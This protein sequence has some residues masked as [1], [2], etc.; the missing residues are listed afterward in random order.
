MKEHSLRDRLGNFSLMTFIFYSAHACYQPYIV[1]FLNARGVNAT[2]IGLI[3]T[4]NSLVAIFMQPLWGML[5]DHFRSVK[6]VAL[7]CIAALSLLIPVLGMLNNPL[8]ISVWIPL[9]NVFYC[10]IFSFMDSWTV[11]GVKEMPGKSYGTV[12]VWGSVG[13]MIAVAISGRLSETYSASV[14]FWGFAILGLVSVF[15]GLF[16]KSEGV[17]KE[18]GVPQHSQR[19]RLRDMNPGKLLKNYY[20]LLFIICVSLIQIPLYAKG[21][22]LPQR[23]IAAGGDSALYGLCMSIGALSEVP[24]LFFSGRLMRRVK[25]GAIVLF[26]MCVYTAQLIAMAFPIPAWA[27][28]VIQ[29]FQGF[30]YGLFLVGSVHYIDS[31][32]PSNLKTSA[33]TFASACYGGIAGMISNMMAGFLIDQWGI[34]PVFRYASIWAFCALLLYFVLLGLGKKFVKPES[35]PAA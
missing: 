14:S 22:Y 26:S 18:A 7:V 29:C 23:V 16:I 4:A 20:Y 28:L 34:M 3:M 11:Q 5:C 19:L 30:G 6:K 32:A 13:F 21:T 17:P 15:I 8:L 24:V 10:T 31:L 12:R 9:I 25:P 27:I 35:E 33:L 2:T 1:V